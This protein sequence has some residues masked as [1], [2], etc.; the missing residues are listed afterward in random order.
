[1]VPVGLGGCR[2]GAQQGVGGGERGTR[3][4]GQEPDTSLP[5]GR[6]TAKCGTRGVAP[7]VA[8]LGAEGVQRAPTSPFV[9]RFHPDIVSVPLPR[10]SQGLGRRFLHQLHRLAS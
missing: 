2:M 8:H 7:H 1:M 3:R 4:N 9:G 6:E 10:G 5:A